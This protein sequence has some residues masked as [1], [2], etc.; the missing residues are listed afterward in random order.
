MTEQSESKIEQFFIEKL[1]QSG[2]LL[3]NLVEA[4]LKPLFNIE[5]DVSYI[6]KDQSIGRRNDFVGSALIPD[7]QR[8]PEGEKKAVVSLKLVIE[9]KSLPDHGWIFFP[10]KKEI[11]SFVDTVSAMK[12]MDPKVD[13]SFKAI[14]VTSIE[15]LFYAGGYAEFFLDNKKNKVRKDKSNHDSRSN[16]R[17]T[18]L[19]ECIHT[20]TKATR[21]Q[22][23]STDQLLNAIYLRYNNLQL[24][25]VL[26]V[27][28]ALIVFK[29]RI[30][31]SEITGDEVKLKPIKLVG[32]SQNEPGQ[33]S[34]ALAQH[35]CVEYDPT[36]KMITVSC[37][38]VHLTDIYSNLSNTGALVKENHDKDHKNADNHDKVWILNSGIVVGKDGSLIIDS[39]DTSWLKITATPT[40]QLKQNESNTTDE[41]PNYSD[42]E[43]T[44]NLNNTPTSENVRNMSNVSGIKDGTIVVSKHNGDNPNGIHVHGSLV[45]DS[46]KITS[47]DPEKKKVIDFGFGKRPGEEHTKSEYDTAEPRGFIRVS[48]DATGTTNITNSEIG[49]LGYSCS[50]CAGLSYYGGDGSII[51][52]SDIRHLLKGYY[53][54]NMGHMIIEG[55]KFHDNYLYG[56]DPH[57]GTRDLIIRNNKVYG[58]NASDIIC[59]KHCYNLLIEGNE[60]YKSG[61]AGRGIAFSIN[62]SN[63]I[64]RNNQVHDNERCISFNRDSNNNHVYNNTISHCKFGI[65]L[66]N[67][68]R[69]SIDG[70]SIAHSDYGIVMKNVTSNGIKNNTIDSTK[71]GIMLI[72]KYTKNSNNTALNPKSLNGTDFD[73]Y[74]DKLVAKNKLLDV[75]TPSFI[76]TGKIKGLKNQLEP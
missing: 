53:S 19:Y 65:Y 29:G 6:D 30:Y 15:D 16:K 47:W 28:Q 3:E 4:K 37:Q 26:I 52:N 57:T 36:Q 66:S 46:V 41:E 74:L 7:G 12:Q 31:A 8:P 56:I 72:N 43:D 22:I 14:P 38:S 49:Y 68:S 18:N 64:A 48:K 23:D 39:N 61:G 11:L 21:H 42:S 44:T 50:R 35:K 54:K 27:F 20:V 55:N 45:I 34:L 76:D 67:T 70:N 63:S 59:S 73:A 51:K 60:V 69:N 58:N 40:M 25:P 33:R 71:T 1:N 75:S 2:Y 62:T 24:I 13:P 17:D 9:C 10:G 5:R 32:I